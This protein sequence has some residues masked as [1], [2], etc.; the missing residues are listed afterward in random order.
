M[1]DRRKTERKAIHCEKFGETGH[2]ESEYL[3]Q[4]Q[5]FKAKFPFHC[6]VVSAQKP[7]QFLGRMI[8]VN[9][10]STKVP[11]S[12]NIRSNTKCKRKLTL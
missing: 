3:Y 5:D 1:R 9:I 2:L 10:R 8:G 6:D 7:P 12:D 4:G 11:E